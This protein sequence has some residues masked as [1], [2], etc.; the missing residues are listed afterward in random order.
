MN[1]WLSQHPTSQNVAPPDQPA[2]S[3][4]G[5]SELHA[6]QWPSNTFHCIFSATVSPTIAPLRY[7]LFVFL[8]CLYGVGKGFAREALEPRIFSCTMLSNLF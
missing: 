8:P 5:L 1:N 2:L 4:A 3:L 6:V 7:P